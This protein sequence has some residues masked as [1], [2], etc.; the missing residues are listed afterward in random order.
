MYGKTSVGAPSFPL[1][2][3]DYGC[4]KIKHREKIRN[5]IQW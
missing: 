5:G 2:V 1:E 4:N 3:Y